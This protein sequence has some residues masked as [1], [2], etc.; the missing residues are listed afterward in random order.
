MK[1]DTVIIISKM[2][3]FVAIGFFTPLT[4]GLA[5][6]ADVNEWPSK[7]NWV[8]IGS[9]CVI[10]GATQLLSFLSQSYS[11]YTQT[12]NGASASPAAQQNSPLTPSQTCAIRQP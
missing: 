1:L 11:Q 9:S 12:R 3:C 4:V 7:I 6:W 8:V 10:G 5:Q 2:A